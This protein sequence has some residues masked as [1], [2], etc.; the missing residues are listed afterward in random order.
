M[1]WASNIHLSMC[2]FVVYLMTVSSSGYI[3]L[4]NSFI[5]SVVVYLTILF[6]D[7]DYIASNERMVSEQ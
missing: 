7:E 1:K 6:C 5:Y 3:V 4:M 2:L